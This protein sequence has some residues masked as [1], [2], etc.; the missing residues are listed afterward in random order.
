MPRVHIALD[1]PLLRSAVSESLRLHPGI[2]VI[3]AVE[4]DYVSDPEIAAAL[5]PDAV[6]LSELG[7]DD[8]AERVADYR[9]AA[10]GAKLVLLLLSGR[11]VDLVANAGADATVDAGD[12]LDELAA[13]IRAVA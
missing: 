1:E 4:S 13:A 7:R 2:E 5:R 8:P 11:A 9:N 6:V 3:D 10:P 12:G